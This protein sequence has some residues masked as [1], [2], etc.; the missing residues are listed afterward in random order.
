MPASADCAPAYT[1]EDLDRAYAVVQGSGLLLIK[2][3]I[4]Y[5]LTGR[6]ERSIRRMFELK[7]RSP[8]K[9]CV[10]PGTREVL[11]DLCP[12][13]HPDAWDWAWA[14]AGWTILAVIGTL[15]PQSRLWLSLPPW[16]RQHTN[17]DGSVAVFLKPGAFV[18]ALV[19]RAVTDRTILVGSSANLSGQGNTFRP[20]DLAPSLIEGA[21]LFLDHGVARYENPERMATTMIDLRTLQIVRR[22]VNYAQLNAELQ[23]LRARMSGGADE[24]TGRHT[25]R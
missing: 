5:G 24:H 22:G 14:Q 1:Q 9:P 11:Q 10:V 13:I 18:E 17:R 15:D 8:K 2:H 16:V 12:D 23:R 6:S 21:D 4:G 20:D 19:E 3:D 7:G 25:D